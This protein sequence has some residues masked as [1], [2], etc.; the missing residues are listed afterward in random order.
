MT[1]LIKGDENLF[2]Y[3]TTFGRHIGIL[4]S[5]F[6][7]T[8]VSACHFTSDWQIS[9]YSDKRRR[10]YDVISIFYDGGHRVRNLLRFAYQISADIKLLPVSKNGQPPY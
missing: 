7:L 5:V 10:S 6:I 1:A 3:K 2:A 4:L 9:Y 8:H